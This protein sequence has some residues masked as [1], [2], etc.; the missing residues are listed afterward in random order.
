[1]WDSGGTELRWDSRLVAR[2]KVGWPRLSC[3]WPVYVQVKQ[4]GEVELV[5]SFEGVLEG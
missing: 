3:H 1:M 2:V 5:F 4:G